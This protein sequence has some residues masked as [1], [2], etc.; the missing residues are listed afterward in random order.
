MTVTTK[1]KRE[2]GRKV[3]INEVEAREPMRRVVRPPVSSALKGAAVNVKATKPSNPTHCAGV[4]GAPLYPCVVMARTVDLSGNLAGEA[5]TCAGYGFAGFVPAKEADN[6]RKGRAA[7]VRT[8]SVLAQFAG[9][10]ANGCQVWLSHGDLA[11]ILG[12]G[13]Q[14]HND[15]GELVTIA[16]SDIPQRGGYGD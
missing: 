3:S 8:D 12:I 6:G 1:T 10:K 5:E 13:G 7:K 9:T 16:E 14:Y 4:Y 2:Q 11:R 15:A